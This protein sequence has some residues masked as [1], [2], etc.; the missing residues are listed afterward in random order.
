MT[1]HTGQCGSGRYNPPGIAKDERNFSA[2][3]S[4]WLHV[5]KGLFFLFYRE[6]KEGLG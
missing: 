3:K 6:E 5:W 1:D 2:Q 4:I